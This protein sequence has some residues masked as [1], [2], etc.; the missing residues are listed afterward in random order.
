MG[1]GYGGKGDE[2]MSI[3]LSILAFNIIIIVHELGHFIVAKLCKMKV[4]EFSL[5]FGP[6]IFSKKIGD[7]VYSLRAIPVIAY[8]KLEGEDTPSDAKDS[9]SNK[10]LW[11][12]M[13][14]IAAGPFANILIAT[15]LLVVIYS[16]TG[17]GTNQLDQI[18]KD[19]PAYTAGLQEG[20]VIKSYDGRAV[21]HP[22]DT[23]LFLTASK[24][25]E[26]SIEVLR[27]GKVEKKTMKPFVM[28]KNRSLLG[29]TAKDTF[30]S[31][32]NVV[33]EL[34]K[35]QPAEMGGLMVDDRII[36]I[37]GN[38]TETMQDIV[39]RLAE[40]GAKEAKITVLRGNGK[41]EL[42]IK[43][44]QD[45]NREFYELG[46]AFKGGVKGSLTQVIQKSVYNTFAYT[47]N[48]VYSIGFL[49]QGKFSLSDM[50]GPVGIVAAINGAVQSEVSLADQ[51]LMLLNLM[52]IIS[53]ALGIS[54]LLP[55]PPADGS[56]LVLHVVEGIR[57]KPLPADKEAFIMM[58]GFV[59]MM[60]LF[61]F[62]LFSDVYK[63]F[64]GA[65]NG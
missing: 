3:I 39:T 46:L 38:K 9:Y 25:K 41:K 52:V 4:L 58:A 27:N 8:V 61:V 2:K 11:A 49:F 34:S 53:I 54:N 57:R 37:N 5:F 35:G 6:K 33:K 65:F 43:P 40:N 22:M 30:G 62:I 29:F 44:V 24:G 50:S 23:S 63:L 17:Y 20:D 32:S 56:K 19:S 59:F 21:Y 28:P 36:A 10:P 7:T 51:V 16:V 15:V 64:T 14:V 60:L 45:T 26:T 48:I 55:I 12:R 18:L 47:R 13:A 42:Y 31:E 1:K